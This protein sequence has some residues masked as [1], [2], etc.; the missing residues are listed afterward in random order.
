VRAS[1]HCKISPE[2][3][4][5]ASVTPPLRGGA[6]PLRSQAGLRGVGTP[7]QWG[8]DPPGLGG[9]E[10]SRRRCH[11]RSPRPGGRP[12]GPHRRRRQPLPAHQRPAPT[13]AA[14]LQRLLVGA[15][16]NSKLTLIATATQCHYWQSLRHSASA[17][18]S[19]ATTALAVPPLPP[20]PP[21]ALPVCHSVPLALALAVLPVSA[22]LP[23]V[24][25]AVR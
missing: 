13:P 15:S 16:N 12:G 23:V 14:S 6:P 2:T 18:D 9:R 19:A 3:G 11:R 24:A 4:E 7:P 17:S 5:P 1:V 25:L 8:E 10:K 20:V 22:T 21:V